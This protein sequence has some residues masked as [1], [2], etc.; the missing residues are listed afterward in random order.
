VGAA[1]IVG[2]VSIPYP[3]GNPD[4]PRDKEYE[5]RM[6]LVKK[7]LELLQKDVM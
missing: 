3:I 1:R 5:L 4:L 7:A 6:N 2:A